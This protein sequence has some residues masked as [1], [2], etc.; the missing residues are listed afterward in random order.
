MSLDQQLLDLFTAGRFSDVIDVAAKSSISPGVAPIACQILA[1]SHFQ[2]G[3]FDDAYSLLSELESVF[4]ESS[5]YLSMYAAT[6][7]RVGHLD[8]ASDLFQRALKISP[9]SKEINNNYA[10][11]LVD[12]RKY[13]E[14]LAILDSL[15]RKYP[16]Y[17]DALNNK[18]RLV[19]LREQYIAA[20][21]GTKS[22]QLSSIN[23]GDP[24]LLAFDSDEVDY[25][26]KRYFPNA[27]RSLG[28]ISSESLDAEDPKA[29]AMDQLKLAEASLK[30]GDMKFVLRLC[31]QSLKVL[32]QEASIY[33]VASDAYL[34]LNQVSQSELCLLHAVALGGLT[35]KRCFN[36]ASFSILRNNF[37]LAESYINKAAALDP[38]SPHLPRI[39]SLLESQRKANT[40]PFLFKQVWAEPDTR[41]S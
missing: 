38:S 28:K 34:N 24:L 1:A 18:N 39:N 15:L 14:A 3:E 8:K 21:E 36:L 19:H 35:P 22:D 33:D 23:L 26:F 41:K 9:D 6:C 30:G 2:L 16:D 25:S 13:D 32:G 31:S 20:N 40:H 12:Q 37:D 4:S 29:V 5:E 7:R 10:N 17:T 11:L 27:I